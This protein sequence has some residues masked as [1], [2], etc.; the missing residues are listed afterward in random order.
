MLTRQVK[1]IFTCKTLL[2]LAAILLAS[3]ALLAQSISGVVLDKASK[4]PLVNASVSGK[5]GMAFTNG[6][7]QFSLPALRPGDTLNV[8]YLGYKTYRLIAG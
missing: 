8:A 4:I 7:G 5:K 3:Q 6:L 1:S 2:W